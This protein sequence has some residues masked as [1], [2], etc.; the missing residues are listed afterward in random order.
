[1][2]CF[3]PK[4]CLKNQKQQIFMKKRPFLNN[5]LP[6]PAHIYGTLLKNDNTNGMDII[7][8]QITILFLMNTNL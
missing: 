3:A 8:V 1:M 7:E 6:P 5:S 4:L 2:E